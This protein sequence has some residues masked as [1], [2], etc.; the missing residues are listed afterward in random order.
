MDE[1][2]NQYEPEILNRYGL[3]KDDFDGTDHSHS[4]TV[5]L[6]FKNGKRI[7]LTPRIRWSDMGAFPETEITFQDSMNGAFP[8]MPNSPTKG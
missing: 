8:E 4:G 6:K 3:K 5:I 7:W 2:T 1:G